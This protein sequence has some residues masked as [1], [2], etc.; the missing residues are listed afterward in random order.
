M[1][2]FNGWWIFY[3]LFL[4]QLL[5][6]PKPALKYF[7]TIK[8]TN[9]AELHIQ[10]NGKEMAGRSMLYLQRPDSNPDN[11]QNTRNLSN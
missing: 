9:K 5:K 10:V 8:K 1:S 11:T 2:F 3:Q 6:P 4:E 7:C